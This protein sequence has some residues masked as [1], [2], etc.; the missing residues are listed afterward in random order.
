M[1]VRQLIE[2]FDGWRRAG[3]RIVLATV[4]A[5]AGST[6]SKPGAQMLISGSGQFR[7]LLSGGCLEGDLVEHALEVLASGVPK[8]VRYD[9]RN[10]DEDELWGLGLGCDGAIDILLQALD[11]RHEP[12]A[13]IARRVAA[14]V[15][16][17]Y[18]LVTA[19]DGPSLPVGALALASAEDA[20][21]FGVPPQCR[22]L[23]VGACRE[24]LAAGG[25]AQSTI[26]LE[27]ATAGLLCAVLPLPVRLLVLGGGPDAAPLVRIAHELGWYVTV[28]DHRRAY[29][30]RMAG[31]GADQALE[32]APL[33]LARTLDPGAFD[34]AVIMSHHLQSDR[35]YLRALSRTRVPYIGLLGPRARRERLLGDLDP[36]SAA[37]VDA[38]LYGP[39]GLDIGA[40]TP[41]GIALAIAAEIHAVLRRRGPRHLSRNGAQEGPQHPI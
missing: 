9:M 30:E 12:F 16:C 22:T 17:A 41:E 35:G 36:P 26:A 28:C 39:V 7:G 8:A 10:R 34:A 19:S 38:R 29:V 2:A 25:A 32:V 27:E 24:R 11:S 4:T 31:S 21:T 20:D 37:R 14:R 23:L 1:S 18:A 13:S 6:Y 5:T 15:P 40:D 33:E 3:E